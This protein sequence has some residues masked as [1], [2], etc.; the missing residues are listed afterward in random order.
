MKICREIIEWEWDA[1]ASYGYNIVARFESTLINLGI[2]LD[3][4][5][6]TQTEAFD[7]KY[8]VM[9]AERSLNFGYGFKPNSFSP[10]VSD[11]G[12]D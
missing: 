12:D 9:P 7:E 2:M 1:Q 11:N 3:Y 5:G 6:I 4:N 8:S 10:E